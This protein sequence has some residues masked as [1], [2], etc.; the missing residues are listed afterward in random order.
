MIN[1]RGKRKNLENDKVFIDLES[2]SVTDDDEIKFRVKT[3]DMRQFDDLKAIAELVDQDG[4]I[5]V[6]TSLFEEGQELRKNAMDKIKSIAEDRG[7]TFFQASDR[8]AVITPVGVGI[9]KCRIRRK[10]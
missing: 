10:K 8:V 3:V 9:D 1:L 7:G 6:E 2:Y 4:I 5:I